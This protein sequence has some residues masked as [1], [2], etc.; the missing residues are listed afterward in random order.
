MPGAAPL[1]P[2]RLARW[3]IRFVLT[4]LASLRF[5]PSTP[6]SA[7]GCQGDGAARAR[8]GSRRSIPTRIRLARSVAGEQPKSLVPYGPPQPLDERIFDLVALAVHTEPDRP[9]TGAAAGNAPR[10]AKDPSL[11]TDARWGS[12]FRDDS[13]PRGRSGEELE[14]VGQNIAFHGQLGDCV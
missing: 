7:S 6:C 9:Q 4:L 13:S 14:R 2:R 8:Y 1:E 10:S 11:R 12:S 3:A 5:F